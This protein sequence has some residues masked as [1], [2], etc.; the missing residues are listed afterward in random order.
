MGGVFINYRIRDSSYAAAAIH[1]D[2]A[3]RFGDDHVFRDCRSLRPGQQYPEEIRTAL[4]TA[5]VVVAVIGPQWLSLTDPDTGQ[6]LIDRED[7]W[8]RRE[9][10]WAFERNIPVLPVLLKD[11]GPLR[12]DHLPE[13]LH[14]LAA[15]QVAEVNH[16]LLKEDVEALSLSG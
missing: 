16:R 4:F 15:I 5:D 8:V 3:A 14:R 10:V 13:C 2:L 1:K 9:I 7:D 6:R 12:R 11:T